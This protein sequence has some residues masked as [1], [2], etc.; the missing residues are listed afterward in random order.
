MFVSHVDQ[1][2]KIP[3]PIPGASNVM[4]QLLV[5]R[6]EG[7]TDHAM[8]LFTVG[9]G[10]NTPKHSHPWPHINYVVSGCGE[11][12]IGDKKHEVKAGSVAFVP[13][14]VEHQ[15]RNLSAEDFVFICIVPH[16]GEY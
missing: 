15:F 4:K 5:G 2:D 10:G 8:R 6:D 14:D 3:M 16:R 13:D 11:L 1:I 12:L 9:R 7:W